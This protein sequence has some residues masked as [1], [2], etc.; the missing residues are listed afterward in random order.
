MKTKSLFALLTAFIVFGSLSAQNSTDQQSNVDCQR[1][2]SMFYQSAKIKQYD[3]A[4]PYYKKII[5]NCPDIHLAVYQYGNRMFKYYIDKTE[6]AAKKKS[7]AE[8]LIQNKKY[9]LKYFPDKT[10]AADTYRSIAQVMV[11]NDI[12]TTEEQY[13]LFDKS[14][15]MDQESFT[16]PKSLYSYFSLLID[17]Q[18][19]GKRNL[20]DVFK[21]YDEVMHKI[22]KEEAMR[23]KQEQDL[24]QKKQE[25][26]SLSAEE[27]RKLNNA[28]IFLKNY[29]L[30]KN[31]IETKVGTRADCENLVP[32]YKKQF[33]AHKTD[34]EWLKIAAK[35]LSTKS[36]TEGDLFFKVTKAL[37]KAE[38]SAESAKYL[39]RL[40]EF[41]GNTSE[42]IK[43]YKQSIELEDSD[44]EQ[45]RIYYHIANIYKDRGSFSSARSYYRKALANNASMGIAYLKIANMYAN[46][47]NSCGESV[48]EKRAVYWLA[49]DYA[50][51]AGQVDPSIKSTADQTAAAY[52]GRAPS[53]SDI[54]KAGKAGQ[55]ISIGCWIN[56]SVTVPSF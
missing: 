39:G 33:E 31:S 6:D 34:V 35:R 49:A 4:R 24:R 2:L 22:H 16:D 18:D 40:A 25:T 19:A 13:K 17:L 38:P 48:F 23:A 12:G 1:A 44:L 28:K 32:L 50:A 55:T 36:C 47:V 37:N 7:L 5:N 27:S 21:K 26:G 41:K 9:R 56:E 10:N 52:N 3:A 20:Q 43:Y 8:K 14:W 51:R 15:N 30:I 53:K 29:M 45:A 54:F 11:N 46:S 42:A